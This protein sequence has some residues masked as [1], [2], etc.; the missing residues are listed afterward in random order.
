MKPFPL[1]RWL[2]SIPL[3]VLAVTAFAAPAAQDT[4]TATAIFAG[5]CFWCMEPPFDKL[6][7]VISTTSGYTGGHKENPT[8]KE[9]SRGGTGHAEAMQ[10]VYDPQRIS[11][12]QLLDVFW[13]NIDPTTSDG[14][15]CD[16][17]DQY[18][19]EIFYNTPEQKQLAE[20]SKAA[21]VELKPFKEPV[22]TGISAASTFYPAEDYHQD[23][24][25]K[26]PVR[27]KFYRY[28]CGR[29]QR[30]E[31]LWGKPE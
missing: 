27:Y 24:Y 4:K 8:Y 14:Q 10:V 25:K 16:W 23:Y 22:V 9:V 20:Q 15:F 17:G 18:R 29:D 26:N 3:A 19:S 13:H 31:E 30:L 2:L 28:G 12:A 1:R 5:G 7:G 21:L 11:Y 6:D